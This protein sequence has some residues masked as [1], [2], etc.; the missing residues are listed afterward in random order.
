MDKDAFLKETALHIAEVELRRSLIEAGRNSE[1]M[2]NSIL[3][4]FGR[5]CHIHLTME[6]EDIPTEEGTD[7]L[8]TSD[9]KEK[10]D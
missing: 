2:A 7:F 1:E 6:F 5:R 10:N 9:Y 3:K 8:A 4:P